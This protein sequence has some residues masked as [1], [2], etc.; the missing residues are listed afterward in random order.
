MLKNAVDAQLPIIAV[1]T[2][3]TVNLPDVIQHLAKKKPIT[4]IPG[5]TKVT[6]ENLYMIVQDKNQKSGSLAPYYLTMMKAESS[7]LVVNP[8]LIEDCYFDAGEVPIP[9]SMLHDMM[10]AVTE[11]ADLTVNLVRALG[12]VTIKEAAEL[13][14]LTMSRDASLTPRGLMLTRKQFF[15]EKSGLYLVNP[16]QELYLPSAELEKWAVNEKSFFLQSPDQ[17]LMPRGILFDGPPGV[18]KTAGA[19]YLA[20]EWGVPLYRFDIGST[21]NK[22]V[23]ESEGNMRANLAR[24]D[25]EEPCIVLFDEME[26]VFNGDDHS[27][28]GTT[29]SMLSQVLW[30]LA[31]HKSRVLSIMTTNKKSKLPPELYR[32]GRID[33]VLDFAGLDPL[34]A[35][36]FIHT[37]ANT[38]DMDFTDDEAN[39]TVENAFMAL[40]ANGLASHASLT[41]ETY[42]TIKRILLNKL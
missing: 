21:K 1:T 4:F 23:G 35:L 40:E 10:L 17:R 9:K 38:F 30:W 31:E 26:K 6:S 41:R 14:R 20:S 39:E 34:K 12:G 37:V 22:Y 5:S 13:S 8:M 25:R 15:Q 33:Q 42:V 19:K 3:D 27:D 24:L 18:G 32:E 36:D 2:Q 7:L 16:E 28:G 11:D 29:Q